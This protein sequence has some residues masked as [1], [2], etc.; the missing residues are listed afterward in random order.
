MAEWTA[1]DLFCRFL[2]KLNTERLR[3]VR[4]S[5]FPGRIRPD[6]RVPYPRNDS[7]LKWCPESL[8]SLSLAEITFPGSDVWRLSDYP[9]LTRLELRDCWNVGQVLD[10]VTRSKVQHLIIQFYD[11]SPQQDFYSCV[12]IKNLQHLEVLNVFHESRVS[13]DHRPPNYDQ[14]HKDTME[15]MATEVF[16]GIPSAHPFKILALGKQW[17]FSG[18]LEA[19]WHRAHLRQCF[20]RSER[21][22][23]TPDEA[24]AASAEYVA[25]DKITYLYPDSDILSYEFDPVEDAPP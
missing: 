17:Y 24:C 8:T 1:P 3:N 2:E 4:L 18:T 6:E 20:S 13:Q 10:E 25:A 12:I 14:V 21:T 7:M 23:I 19:H 15:Q 11:V 5:Y 22:A 9:L 16:K